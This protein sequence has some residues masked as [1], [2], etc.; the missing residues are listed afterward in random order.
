MSTQ[1]EKQHKLAIRAWTMYDWANSAFATT[2]MAAVLP[3]YYTT[4]AASNLAPHLATARWG[5]TSSISALIAAVISPILGAVADFSGAKKALPCHFHVTRGNCYCIFCTLYKAATG[6][7]L[8]SFSSLAISA[9]L[10]VWY[11]TMRCCHTSPARMRLIRSAHAG[12][13]WAILAEVSCWQ[14]T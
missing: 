8:L 5:F 10:A 3:V 2:I 14:S 7:L 11:I 9:S 13:P 6:C 4:V 12:T 1:D